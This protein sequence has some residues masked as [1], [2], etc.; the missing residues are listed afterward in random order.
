MIDFLNSEGINVVSDINKISNDIKIDC[1][2]LNH[3]LEHL[4]DPINT[5]KEIKKK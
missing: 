3:V 5:L 1:I 4:T 2:M